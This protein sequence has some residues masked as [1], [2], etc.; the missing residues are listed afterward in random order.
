VFFSRLISTTEQISQQSNG[1]I[2]FSHNKSVFSAY[3][4]AEYVMI[5]LFLFFYKIQMSFI[6]H[7][8]ASYIDLIED[9]IKV[10][11]YETMPL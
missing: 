9:L 8:F 4:S 3:F 7:D 1:T 2:F 10:T 6:P 11:C 5:I